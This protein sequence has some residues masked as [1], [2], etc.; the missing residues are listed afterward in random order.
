MRGPAYTADKEVYGAPSS[1]LR[2]W[3]TKDGAFR[4]SMRIGMP[5]CQ[6]IYLGI[7]GQEREAMYCHSQELRQAVKRK[8][9]FGD[10][11]KARAMWAM[12]AAKDREAKCYDPNHHK[13][14]QDRNQ[15]RLGVWEVHLKS[16]VAA[17]AKVLECL[18][19]NEGEPLPQVNGDEQFWSAKSLG[20]ADAGKG[21]GLFLILAMSWEC[22]RLPA[23]GTFRLSMGRKASSS[24]S[25]SFFFFI[26]FVFFFF[27][28]SSSSFFMTK[29]P[30]LRRT[31]VAFGHDTPLEAEEY[32]EHNVG[33]V[34]L[35]VVKQ[36]WSG[37]LVHLFLEDWELARVAVSC[38]LAFDLLCQEM[39]VA[40]Q[41]WYCCQCCHCES[42]S[43]LGRAATV[44]EEVPKETGKDTVK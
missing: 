15:S 39:Q 19:W 23:A 43:Y 4:C 34:S 40:W 13:D 29:E 24:S 25:S 14:N 28:S 2:T 20:R 12:R 17:L 1:T 7:E 32:G 16:P 31:M 18:V 3:E 38:H 36:G 42:L 6:A 26:F 10:N 21:C 9:T 27:S 11:Q 44:H 8:K 33:N 5:F 30:I 41:L 37:W 35:E 22:A